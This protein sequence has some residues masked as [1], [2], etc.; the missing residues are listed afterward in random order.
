MKLGQGKM[1]LSR[2]VDLTPNRRLAKGQHSTALLWGSRSRRGRGS[3][4]GGLRGELRG[5][6][7]REGGPK[8]GA[9]RRGQ[10]GPTASNGAAVPGGASSAGPGCPAA[11]MWEDMPC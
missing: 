9:C 10:R 3:A 1:Q 7:S 8:A 11:R 5:A 2:G 6:G 4:V